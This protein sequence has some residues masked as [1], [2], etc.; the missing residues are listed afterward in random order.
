[1]D[2]TENPFWC[3]TIL[4]VPSARSMNLLG[5]S[6]KM[7]DVQAEEK[8]ALDS[9]SKVADSYDAKLN[10][11]KEKLKNWQLIFS[12]TTIVFVLRWSYYDW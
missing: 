12:L 5:I 11:L 2:V 8:I 6:K 10:K 1:M 7:K 3:K 4:D 9:V